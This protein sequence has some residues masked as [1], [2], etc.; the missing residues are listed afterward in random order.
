M[1]TIARLAAPLGLERALAAHLARDR[2]TNRILAGASAARAPRAWLLACAAATVVGAIYL[3]HHG[4]ALWSAMSRA[5]ALQL[6]ARWQ[7][8]TSHA[9][10]LVPPTSPTSSRQPAA[11]P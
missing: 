1:I 8:H 7:Q 3:P 4:P 9:A 6:A 2:D 5:A 10:C 11:A